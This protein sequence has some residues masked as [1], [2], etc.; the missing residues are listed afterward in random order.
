M[1]KIIALLCAA[2]LT[3]APRT[4]CA[5]MADSAKSACVINGTTGEV[6]FAK[7]ETERLPMASTTKIMTAVTAIEHSHPD[8][9]VTVSAAASSQEG[10]SAYIETG[11]RLSMRDLLYGLMLNSG[12]DAAYAIAE[13][14]SGNV[15]DFAELMNEKAEELGLYDT[16][17]KNPSGL[18]DKEHYTTALDLAR[19]ARYAMTIPEIRETVSTQKYQTEAENTGKTLYFSNHNKML[20]MYEGAT[21]VKT[22]FTR[23]AGRCLV[24]SAKRDGMEFIAV[25]LGDPND[26]KDHAEM[27]DFA[28]SKY[29]PKCIVKKGMTVKTAQIGGEK[30]AMTAAEDFVMPLKECGGNNIDVITHISQN[31]S[32]PINAGEKV[33]Y[34]EIRYGGETVG[35]VDI[36][37]EQDITKNGS[38]KIKNSFYAHFM[39]VAEKLL[40]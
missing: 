27:L 34:L 31:L 7:N 4:V 11:M 25:T 20:K 40:I 6:I 16:H 21:G 12:N 17:F 19:T 22:G 23:A 15:E 39:R 36:I 14:I 38:V 28:F 1:R 29:Y 5:A 13:H 9:V 8:D 18:E 26:W 37:S 30:Y 35:S 24:S 3:A 33:G 32:P 2:C 10:S